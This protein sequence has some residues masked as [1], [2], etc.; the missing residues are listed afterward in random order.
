MKADVA[1]VTENF[2]HNHLDSDPQVI[3]RSITL[4]GVPTRCRRDT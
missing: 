3:G 1:L 4:N 2:W